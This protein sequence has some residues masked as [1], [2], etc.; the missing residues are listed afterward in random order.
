[1]TVYNNISTINAS[2][3]AMSEVA[4]AVTGIN[5]MPSSFSQQAVDMGAGRGRYDTLTL[6]PEYQNALANGLDTTG[7]YDTASVLMGVAGGSSSSNPTD[8]TFLS[9]DITSTMNI[10]PETMTAGNVLEF[11]QDANTAMLDTALQMIQD[12]IANTDGLNVHNAAE[13]Q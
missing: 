3:E 10:S 8:L 2:F 13:N 6:S 5:N 11:F 9:P 12:T 7:E 1:M 4:S